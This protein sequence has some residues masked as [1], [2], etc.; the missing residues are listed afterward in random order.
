MRL[1]DHVARGRVALD[2]TVDDAHA[3]ADVHHRAARRAQPHGVCLHERRL[4][5]HHHRVVLRVQ[6][7]VAF[8]PYAA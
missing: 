1:N 5:L 8:V 7:V 3:K 6:Q 4:P 2:G